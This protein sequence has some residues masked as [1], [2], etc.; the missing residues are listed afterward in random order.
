M[1][2]QEDSSR[3]F[4]TM[5]WDLIPSWAKD[6]KL[7][8]SLINARLETAATKPAFRSAWKARRCLIPTS[9]FYEW[10]VVSQGLNKKQ[11]AS[12]DA[13]LYLAP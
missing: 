4:K 9:G 2:V 3:L 5:R 1:A 8:N 10:R 7:G 12:Y 6:G 13:V 11:E